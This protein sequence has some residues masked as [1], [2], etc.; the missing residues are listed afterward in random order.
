ML[1]LGICLMG[2]VAFSRL[3]VELFP[4]IEFP[5]LLIVTPYENATPVEVE[6][7]VTRHIEEA[8]SGVNGVRHVYSESIEG[9]SIVTARFEW[10]TPMDFTLVETR[11][12]IDIIRDHLPQE[13]GRSIVARHDPNSEPA[14][15]YAV[16]CVKGDSEKCATESRRR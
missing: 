15:L 11:E 6:Q 3:K 5:P 1:F 16:T 14:M 9:M 4:F 7:L 13:S 8:V 10:G 12:K 2:C